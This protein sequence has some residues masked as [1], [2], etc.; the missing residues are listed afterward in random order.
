MFFTNE[1]NLH[2]L[3]E[4][5]SWHFVYLLLRQDI[6]G[7]FGEWSQKFQKQFPQSRKNF[8]LKKFLRLFSFPKLIDQFHARSRI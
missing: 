7:G 5:V 4:Q 1:I 3:L 6:F 2:V 8:R